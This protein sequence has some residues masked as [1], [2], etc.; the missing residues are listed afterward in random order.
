MKKVLLLSANQAQVPYPVPPLGLALLHAGLKKY[1]EVRIVDGLNLETAGL[2]SILFAFRP[3]YIGLSIRNIDDMVK[4]QA[5]SFLPEILENFVAPIKKYKRAVLVLGGAGFTIFPHELLDY[6]DADYG[7]TGEG[8]KNFLKLLLALDRGEDVASIGGVVQRGSRLN[9]GTVPTDD[10]SASLHA[11]LDILIDY[12][13]YRQRGAYPIQTKRG[14]TH[15]C[16]YCSYPVLEGRSFRVRSAR[17]VVDEIEQTAGR[18]NDPGLVFEFVDS[19][20]NDPAGHAEAVCREILRR[21]LTV[22]LRTMG[23]NPANVTRNLLE[24]MLEAGFTQIDATPDSGSRV[25]LRNYRKNFS[26]EQLAR[27]AELIRE[28]NMPTMWFFIFGGPGETEETLAESFTFIDNHVSADDMVNIT[29]GL[30]IYPKTALA[31]SAV[32]EGVVGADQSLL[33]PTFYVSAHFPGDTLTQR[34]DEMIASRPNCLRITDTRPPPELLQAALA[35][36]RD[37]QL[38]EPMFRTLLRLK[39]QFTM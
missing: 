18:I 4:G 36:R 25:M 35:E 22:S 1:Y 17:D 10:F 29:E 9:D 13:P 30:R 6:L 28:C 19:T 39:K 23:M 5:H 7:I 37:K 20:F 33:F 12:Q 14:C 3:D 34:I 15:R 11:D 21:G 2:S 27:A 16:I 38:K 26:L 31:E 8:E 24:L 32:R